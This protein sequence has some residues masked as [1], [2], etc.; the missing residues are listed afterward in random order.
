MSLKLYTDKKEL[1]E[2]SI[3]LEGVKLQ[4]SSIRAILE[5]NDKKY[6]VDGNIKNTG[7]AVDGSTRAS[8]Q[9][10]IEFPKLKNIAEAGESGTMVLEII[11]DD[12]YFQPYSEKFIIDTSKKATVEV[13]KKAEIKPR[14][15]VEKT[16]TPTVKKATPLSDIVSLFEARGITRKELYSNK[17]KFSKV[18]YTYYQQANIN[19]SYADYLKEIISRL[20]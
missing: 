2:C 19:E 15:V 5:F 10:T 12:A 1:F 20:K 14:V 16:T 7:V 8:G 6:L 17:D 4:D 18:L 3:E 9:A 13:V 11:A